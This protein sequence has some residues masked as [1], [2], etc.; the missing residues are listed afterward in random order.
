M[1]R[2]RVSIIVPVFNGGRH[3]DE[4]VGS[5]LRQDFRDWELLLIDDGS[6]DVSPAVAKSYAASQPDRVRYL[7]HPGRE[8]RGQFATR[9]FGARQARADALALL[10]QDDVWDSNYLGEHLRVWD[11]VRPRDV[12]LSYGP[13]LYWFPDEPT[14]SKD[15]VQPM[16]PGA[17]KVFPPGQLLESFFDTH[18]RNTPCPSC[19]LA[20][21][22]V[23]LG[24]L[25]RFEGPAKGS[26]CEDQYLWWYVAV[27][28]PVA[29]HDSAWV[30][31]RQHDAST[32]VVGAASPARARRAELRFLQAIRDD[33]TAQCPGHPLMRGGALAE[34]IAD[35]TV[36]TSPVL[37]AAFP[38]RLL[39]VVRRLLPA[40]VKCAAKRLVHQ[41]A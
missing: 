36:E 14:G 3:L 29:V 26:H 21:R 33:M 19:T 2:P 41:R 24:S 25:K 5:V 23:L 38:R 6:S 17:P 4:T 37:S 28:W 40:P 9:I 16:P 18:Y 27:R 13:S 31:Y 7:E 12:A 15:F 1:S 22:E 20:R 32:L 39:R 30:R 10:D 34:R 35:L 11:A 8:N